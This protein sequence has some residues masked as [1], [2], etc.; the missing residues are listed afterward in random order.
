MGDR[1]NIKVIG[2]GP[3]AIYFYTHNGGSYLDE[4]LKP[5]IAQRKRWSDGAYL[6]RMIFCQMVKNDISGEYGYGIATS[7]P[8]NEHSILCVDTNAQII[9]R[10]GSNIQYTF[11]RYINIGTPTEEPESDW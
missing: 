9:Y 11:E 4:V 1:G 2:A 3:H 8:D 10:E 7:P 6:A 5:V